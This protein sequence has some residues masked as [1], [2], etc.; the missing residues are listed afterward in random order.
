MVFRR[1]VYLNYVGNLYRA[2]RKTEG[3]KGAAEDRSA[4][5]SCKSDQRV[6][7]EA[8]RYSGLLSSAFRQALIGNPW[9]FNFRNAGSDVSVPSSPRH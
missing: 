6:V 2:L 5:A 3:R 7:D 1:I 8:W 4:I 9:V